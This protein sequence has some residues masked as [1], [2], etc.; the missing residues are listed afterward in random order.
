MNADLFGAM[1]NHDERCLGNT[2]TKNGFLIDTSF[3]PDRK[4]P[5][6][7]AICHKR[8]N[9]GKWIVIGWAPDIQS[10]L[11]M[12]DNF[13]YTFEFFGKYLPPFILDAYEN[14]MCF[15]EEAEDER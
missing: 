1:F 11:D 14:K 8:Y 15:L 13:C 4:L 7:T 5:Y 12:H 3:T 10:A 9:G 6:E 2:E